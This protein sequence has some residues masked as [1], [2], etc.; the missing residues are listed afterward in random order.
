M[1]RFHQDVAGVSNREQVTLLKACDE[2]RYD[3]VV[4]SGHKPE[5]NAGFI[6]PS[7]K[8]CNRS[9]YLWA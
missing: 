5:L 3:M 9:P 7:L 8:I 4:C 6:Q 1:G 2:V